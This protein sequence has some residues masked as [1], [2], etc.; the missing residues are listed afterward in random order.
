MQFVNYLKYSIQFHY[1]VIVLCM[2]HSATEYQYLGSKFVLI[3]HMQLTLK[4]WCLLVSEK[5][6]IKWKF[7]K[8]KNVSVFLIGNIHGTFPSTRDT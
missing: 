3:I 1:V 5:S 2:A 4:W 7:I 6:D 8:F